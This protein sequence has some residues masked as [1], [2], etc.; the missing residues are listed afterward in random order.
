MKKLLILL[1]LIPL[2]GCMG[3]ALDLRVKDLEV[4]VRELQSQQQD[5]TEM[6]EESK[7]KISDLT[8]DT[9]AAS[10]DLA[11]KVDV[12]DTTQAASGTTKYITFGNLAPGLAALMTEGSLA[13]S[14]VVSADIKDDSIVNADINS[15]AAIA[16]S[17]LQVLK[18][19]VAGK[20]LSGGEN[21]VLPGAD[22]DTTLAV[23]PTEMT[24]NVAWDDDSTDASITWTWKLSGADD[25]VWTISDSTMNLSNGA[26]QVGGVNVVTT[27]ASLADLSDGTLTTDF[28]N[29]AN[30]W[31]DNEVSGTLTLDALIL[32]NLSGAPGSPATKRLYLADNDTWDPAGIG[33]AL[34]YWTLYDGANWIGLFNEDGG[35]YIKERQFDATA[36]G[37][38]DG[39]YSGDVISGIDAGE[40]IAWGQPVFIASDG[41]WDEADANAAGEFPAIGIAVA[42]P[43]GGGF[44]CQD[45]EELT[46]LVRGVLRF[47]TWT[48]ATVGGK[49]Y[50]SETPCG[51]GACDDLDGTTDVAPSDS[52]DAVQIVGFAT[53]DDE[54][55]FDF[56]RPYSEVE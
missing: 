47:D 12:S 19:I 15:S 49:I 10:G 35:W 25:P 38:P 51:S 33:G 44:P 41:K 48:W 9:T 6:A 53:T 24:G 52:G 13:N 42:C 3:T 16:G 46:V 7:T 11:V 45:T 43:G 23:D 20:G 5:V 39:G 32:D 17:K 40:D 29:T 36:N 4:R 55:Y 50:L 28:V 37:L 26:L 8:A 27:T 21:D 14:I 31:A 22:A 56:S 54:G 34:A 18:D 30:P 2:L 1:L